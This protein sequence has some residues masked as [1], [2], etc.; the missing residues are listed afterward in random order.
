MSQ[1]H[2]VSNL[3][4]KCKQIF[5]HL[6]CSDAQRVPINPWHSRVIHTLQPHSTF[7]VRQRA[8][9][10]YSTPAKLSGS[11]EAEGL[12]TGWVFL[13]FSTKPETHEDAC[14]QMSQDDHAG[15][16]AWPSPALV[17]LFSLRDVQQLHILL[18]CPLLP[19]TEPY[20][21]PVTLTLCIW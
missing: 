8:G 7:A 19:V 6:A 1:N 5:L 14:P 4:F 18:L 21:L 9:G 20:T 12:I 15:R 13:F 3:L 16:I 17:L 10:E 2:W 11:C